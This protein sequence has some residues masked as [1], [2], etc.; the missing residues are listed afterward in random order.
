MLRGFGRVSCRVSSPSSSRPPPLTGK[1]E[2]RSIDPGE[3]LPRVHPPPGA[4]ASGKRAWLTVTRSSISRTHSSPGSIYR[5]CNPLEG[6]NDSRSGECLRDYIGKAISR[7]GS[8]PSCLRRRRTVS[9]SRKPRRQD[10]SLRNACGEC[11]WNYIR[12][13]GSNPAGS[14]IAPLVERDADGPVAQLVEQER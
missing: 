10:C 8:I 12:V 6:M 3:C 7:E 11:R 14:T 1:H 4:L 9:R 5:N 2:L 13:V